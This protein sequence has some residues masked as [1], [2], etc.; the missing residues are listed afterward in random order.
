MTK[1]LR[2]GLIGDFDHTMPSHRA[3]NSALTHAAEELSLALAI[4]WLGTAPL[5]DGREL[6]ELR[7]FKGLLA[8]PGSPYHSLEGALAGIR[9]AREE[10]SPFFAT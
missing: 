2:I 9:L 8:A 7:S 10:G 5:E 6:E 1:T 4:E 3:T